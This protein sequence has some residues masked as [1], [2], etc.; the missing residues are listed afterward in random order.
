M[1]PALLVSGSSQDNQNEAVKEPERTQEH[2][3]PNFAGGQH[4][5]EYLLVVSLKKKILGDDYEPT[6]T[7]QFPKVRP[8]GRRVC[9]AAALGSGLLLPALPGLEL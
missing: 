1:G 7:Y 8:G 3:L 2:P 4:F 6:I 5:F 9:M